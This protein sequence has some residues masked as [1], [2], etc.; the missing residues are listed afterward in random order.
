MKGYRLRSRSIPPDTRASDEVS[1]PQSS[2][3]YSTPK[4]PEEGVVPVGQCLVSAG[5]PAFKVP[6]LPLPRTYVTEMSATRSNVTVR[7]TSHKTSTMPE[8]RLHSQSSTTSHLRSHLSTV[9]TLGHSSPHSSVQEWLHQVTPGAPP[10]TPT[11]VTS[12]AVSELP[13]GAT[14]SALASQRSRSSRHSHSTLM[15]HATHVAAPDPQ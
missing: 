10:P 11:V 12:Q 6:C 2:E 3:S 7:N 5:Q 4:G 14:A 9:Y 15:V 8:Y 13:L 1:P